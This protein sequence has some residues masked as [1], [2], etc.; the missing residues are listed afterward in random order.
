MSFG[1][2]SCNIHLQQNISS[3]YERQ[4][5]AVRICNRNQPDRSKL[6]IFGCA[7]YAFIDPARKIGK[8]VD[9]AKL[10]VGK[11]GGSNGYLLYNRVGYETTTQG[12]VKFVENVD[13]YGK[14]L[15]TQDQTFVYN[16]ST[17]THTPQV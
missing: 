8:L 3:A 5:V 9:R 16:Y 1:F 12:I 15:S 14:V 11:D 17:T 6:R 2:Q 10:Y 13:M 4:N 7:A